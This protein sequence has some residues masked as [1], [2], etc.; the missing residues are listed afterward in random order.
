MA[1]VPM[2]VLML[3]GGYLS[4][5]SPLG[6]ED[7]SSGGINPSAG[8]EWQYSLT[9]EAKTVD[10]KMVAVSTGKNYDQIV[11]TLGQVGVALVNNLPGLIREIKSRNPGISDADAARA[12]DLANKKFSWQANMPWII[13]GGAALLGALLMFGTRRR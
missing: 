10:G 6:A 7:Y 9:G 11:D 5:H 3:G 8:E 12:A 4:P 13:L 1:S 2:S